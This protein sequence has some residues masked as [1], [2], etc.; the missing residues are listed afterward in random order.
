MM[1]GYELK[2]TRPWFLALTDS[3]LFLV[4]SLTGPDAGRLKPVGP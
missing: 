4:N 2:G 3:R 1:K